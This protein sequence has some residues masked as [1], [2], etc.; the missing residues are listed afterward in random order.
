MDSNLAS[1]HAYLCADGYVIKSTNSSYKYYRIGLRNKSLVPLKDF[2]NKFQKVFHLI[3]HICKE[4]CCRIGSKEVYYKLQ[5]S[6]GSFYSKN[7]KLPT[8]NKQCLRS[9]LRSYF[10]CEA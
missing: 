5:K 3:P 10:D 2:Q 8:L 9:W 6:F 1:L 4:D 7:W